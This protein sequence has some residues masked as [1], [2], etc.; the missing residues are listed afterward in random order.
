MDKREISVNS[1]SKDELTYEV[2]IRSEFPEATVD[3]LRKQLKSLL[4]DC[5]SNS[6]VETELDP[7]TESKIITDKIHDLEKLWNKFEQ[8]KENY[9]FIKA[10]TLANHLFHRISRVRPEDTQTQTQIK[11][12]KHTLD[13]FLAK[14][15]NV[16]KVSLGCKAGT[17]SSSEEQHVVE[18][19]CG[20]KSILKWNIKFNGHTDPRSFLE[21]IE[22]LQRADGVSDSKLLNSAT[23]LFSDQALIWFR[24]NR[25]KV[26]SWQELQ[27][28]LL[29]DFQDPEYDYKLSNEIRVRTQGED[30]PLHL[31]FA[32][33]TA[34]F[35]RLSK[36]LAE[37]EKLDI[38]QRN[39]RPFY[40][41][42]L[43][44]VD[45]QS[46]QE[47]EE[48]CRVIEVTRQRCLNFQE[49]NKHNFSVISPEFLYKPQRKTQSAVS[50][51]SFQ[52]NSSKTN[53]K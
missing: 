34:M 46:I 41:Q 4:K 6:I 38:L 20:H 45:I 1:L 31:Y 19:D 28:L 43:A 50:S 48:K 3:S 36:P 2:E 49:P 52:A 42:Q 51:V 13:S 17:S 9:T 21:H 33:M 25:S 15:D 7:A 5:P 30:E 39:I 26:S 35:N 44:L 24:A 12:C 53:F 22:D 47:L 18:S 10:K 16:G 40:T 14:L 27:A 37:K 29:S 8:H 23:R 11:A 32:L